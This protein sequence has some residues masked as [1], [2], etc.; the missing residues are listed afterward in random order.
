M[1]QLSTGRKR[2]IL[3]VGTA[4]AGALFYTVYVG[5]LL[6]H[7]LPLVE[8]DIPDIGAVTPPR[9]VILFLATCGAGIAYGSIWIWLEARAGNL[10]AARRGCL[11]AGWIGI[12]AGVPLLLMDYVNSN[13]SHRL[14]LSWFA[15]L[16]FTL[17]GPLLIL[18]W[19]LLLLLY[20]HHL[21]RE[22]R[23]SPS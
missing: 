23:R 22:I 3:V 17:A 1:S 21:R 16:L 11:V 14:S 8:P 4:A 2:A 6:V 15:E 10:Q 9:S 13:V 18:P 19:S 20:A 5:Q 12:I 7:V